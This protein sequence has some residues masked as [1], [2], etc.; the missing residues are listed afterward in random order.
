MKMSEAIIL[1]TLLLCIFK[2]LGILNI[3]WIWCFIL[4]W[5]PIIC[6]LIISIIFLLGFV[7]YI[8]I[9]KFKK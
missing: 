6:G 3:A 9:K 5:F 4:I 8:I 7:I 1:I 2:L